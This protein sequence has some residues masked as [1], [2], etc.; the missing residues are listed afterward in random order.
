MKKKS[1][2]KSMIIIVVAIILVAL[3]SIGAGVIYMNNSNQKSKTPTTT[4]PT[5][6]TVNQNEQSN[7]NTE[8]PEESTDNTS[9][10][11]NLDVRQISKEHCLND[12]C[13]Y[14]V[15]I[16]QMEQN[17]G[18]NVNF[19]LFNEGEEA[20]PEGQLEM[21]FDNGIKKSFHYSNVNAHDK[22]IVSFIYDKDELKDAEDYKIQPLSENE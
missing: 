1:K 15:I 12:L 13:I 18:G 2:N 8:E 21:V 9:V 5:E 7:T 10:A 4:T 3:V 19:V 16:G 17:Q 20:I 6:N 11:P 22:V 14:S